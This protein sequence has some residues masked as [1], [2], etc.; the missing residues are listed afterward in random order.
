MAEALKFFSQNAAQQ[1]IILK[2]MRS[3]GNGVHPAMRE[4]SV[5]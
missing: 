3:S 2:C 4:L 5:V 1:T